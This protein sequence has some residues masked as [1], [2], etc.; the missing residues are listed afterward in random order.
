M[1]SVSSHDLFQQFHCLEQ[2]E[3]VEPFG[4]PATVELTVPPALLALA[5]KV[6]E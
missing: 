1:T 5:D 3:C 4:E 6:I 2:V